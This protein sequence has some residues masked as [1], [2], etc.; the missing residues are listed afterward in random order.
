MFDRLH[1]CLEIDDG[2]S[3]YAFGFRNANSDNLET[4]IVHCFRDDRGDL[5][6][7]DI[8]PD[9]ISISVSQARP[10]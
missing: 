4:G 3:S 10:S 1:G 5:R 6:C 7:A 9:E 2:A 8:Q